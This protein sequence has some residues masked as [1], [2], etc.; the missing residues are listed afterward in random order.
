M[1]REG[2]GVGKIEKT[3]KGQRSWGK[4]NKKGQ[5]GKGKKS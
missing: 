1:K 4:R 5:R 3:E 2:G